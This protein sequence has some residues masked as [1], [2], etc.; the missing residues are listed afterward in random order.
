[1]VI[2]AARAV[3]E[4]ADREHDGHFDQHPDDGGESGGRIRAE[5]GDGDSHRQFKK[6]AGTDE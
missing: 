1:M 6:I 2:P 3:T 5:Q 4:V